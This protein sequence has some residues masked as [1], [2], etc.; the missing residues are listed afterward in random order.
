MAPPPDYSGPAQARVSRG[1]DRRSVNLTIYNDDLALVREV[2][3]LDLAA[4]NVSLELKDVAAHVDP[5]TLYFRPKDAG[6]A[7]DV[8]EQ[9]FRYDLL[10][11]ESLLS[12]SVGAKVR[13]HRW[14]SERG[15]ETTTDAV[16]LA[17]EGG[18]PVFQVGGEIVPRPPGTLAFP[19]LPKDL[20]AEPTLVVKVR[21]DRA[22]SDVE[23]AYLTSG[24][25]WNV[26]YTLTLDASGTKGALSG[27]VT[28]HDESGATFDDASLQL[29]A[30]DVH[31]APMTETVAALDYE[32]DDSDKKVAEKA[33][34]FTEASFFEYHLYSLD[35]RLS[36]RD[37]EQK[38]LALLSAQDVPVTERLS[39]QAQRD[40]YRGRR[41]KSD[42]PV[43]IDLELHNTLADHLGMPLPKGNVR[44]LVPDSTGAAELAGS[45]AIDHTARDETLR[46]RL[47]RAFDVTAERRQVDFRDFGRCDWMSTWEIDLHDA[48]G[49]A[50]SI[51]VIEPVDGDFDISS[52]SVPFVKKDAHTIVFSSVA[53]PAG[54]TT[55]VKYTVRVRGC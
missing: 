16:L 30:G 40:W 17:Y 46:L 28:L 23:I 19:E 10:S 18:A 42:V 37:H 14:D 8:V 54:G 21:S 45:A 51:D 7:I 33:P 27:W 5:S 55:T 43:D 6:A 36:I 1:A 32:K 35:R 25:G 13:F 34:A 48:K 12:R 38:Q 41:P 44:L 22:K 20:L 26:D 9:D 50:R 53:V 31:R 3:T 4:G 52:P 11:P 47:G 49:V 2:R 39:V 15:A 29:V 24:F